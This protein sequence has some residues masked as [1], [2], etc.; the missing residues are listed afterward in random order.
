M[1]SQEDSLLDP[2]V[3][4]LYQRSE[5]Q[6]LIMEKLTW[7]CPSQMSPVVQWEISLSHSTVSCTA[8]R[9]ASLGGPTSR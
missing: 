6:L 5:L 9:R 1:V 8:V 7:A 2:I 3:T 4:R